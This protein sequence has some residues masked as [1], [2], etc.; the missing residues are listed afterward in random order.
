MNYW[1]AALGKYVVFSGRARRSEY[2][3]FVL[4]NSLFAL[5]WAFLVGF[6]G[7]LGG[8][9]RTMMRIFVEL[10]PLATLLPTIA[11]SIRRLHDTGRTGWWYLLALVPILG[12][13][14][15]I[16]FFIEEGPSEENRYG[17]DP[18]TPATTPSA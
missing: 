10:V 17:P 8:E 6:C 2:W 3:Y 11:V 1:I 14:V 15:L 4:F 12:S 13:I 18:R 7:S 16:V 5:A 9:N